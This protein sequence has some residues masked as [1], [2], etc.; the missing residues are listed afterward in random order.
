MGKQT[1]RRRPKQGAP[2]PK[3]A[4]RV[5]FFNED[6]PRR[7]W[8]VYRR[9]RKD[10]PIHGPITHREHLRRSGWKWST[11]HKRMLPPPINS[12]TFYGN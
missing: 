3:A 10:N 4:R 1:K 8:D 11:K 6:V 9:W 2:K 5:K 7:V 12:R